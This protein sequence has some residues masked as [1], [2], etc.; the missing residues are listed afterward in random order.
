MIRVSALAFCGIV[1]MVGVLGGCMADEPGDIAA[2]SDPLVQE[3]EAALEGEVVAEGDKVTEDGKAEGEVGIAAASTSFTSTCSG[4]R[5]VR[6][7]DGAV[8]FAEASSCRMRNG[9]WTGYRSWSGV[10][11]SDVSNNNGNIICFS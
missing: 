3:S 1:A 8:T 7:A 6:R 9:S 10:C 11:W 5:Y 4:W 2:Q